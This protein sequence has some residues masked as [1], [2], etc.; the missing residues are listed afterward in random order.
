MNKTIAKIQRLRNR[1]AGSGDQAV[2]IPFEIEC[3]CGATVTGVRRATWIESECSECAATVFVLPMNVYPSTKSV[4]SEILGGT[5]KER[6]GVVT[7][8]LLR[9]NKPNAETDETSSRSSSADSSDSNQQTVDAKPKW[10]LPK[11][12]LP[13]IDVKKIV[14]RTFSPFRLVMMAVIATVGFTGWF[15]VQQRQTE[16]AQKIWLESTATIAE[17]LEQEELSGLLVEL[18]SAL[19]AGM[20]L[21]KDDSEY[22]LLNNL[23]VE[24]QAT[25]SLASAGLVD[26]FQAAYDN[27][28]RLEPAAKSRVDEACKQGWFLFDAVA[29]KFDSGTETT[30]LIDFPATPGLHPVSIIL[31]NLVLTQDLDADSDTRLLFVA[32]LSV[33]TAPDGDEDG[34]WI[35][36][37]NPDS[38]AMLTHTAHFVAVGFDPD[39]DA[40]LKQV[41]ERQLG[42]VQS[43]RS[44]ILPPP[45]LPEQNVPSDTA[46]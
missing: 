8:E 37:V 19:N 44:K 22:R 9:G 10:K 30:W 17:K 42:W 32:K 13:S 35:L 45:E 33:K 4:P 15:M 3:D 40:G 34:Q 12:T 31:P 27:Q 7:K 18:E 46:T 6:L 2:E 14:R 39:E 5:F 29:N 38:F 26:V 16:R 23:L 43:G 1:L 21:G 24:T 36:T 28:N 11:L 25:V 41:I 20:V